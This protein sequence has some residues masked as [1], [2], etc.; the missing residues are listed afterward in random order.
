M[1]ILVVMFWLYDFAMM[2]KAVAT[3]R[4]LWPGR[5]EDKEV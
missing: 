5:D 4:I 1:T 2:I 3:K